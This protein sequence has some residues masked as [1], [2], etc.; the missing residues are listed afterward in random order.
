MATHKSLHHSVLIFG[1]WI[2]VSRLSV[3]T[4]F[5]TET[6][7]IVNGPRM[8]SMHPLLETL[9]GFPWVF[10]VDVYLPHSIDNWD[11]NANRMVKNDF[12]IWETIVPAVN[13]QPAIPHNS[14]VKVSLLCFLLCF[15]YFLRGGGYYSNFY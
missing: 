15:P 4:F 8:P 3:S 13:R 5:L 2:R 1:Y 11:R 10:L 6:S 14:K 7:V 9:V 12:G